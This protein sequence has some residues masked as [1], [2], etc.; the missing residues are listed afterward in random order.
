[1]LYQAY[2]LLEFFDLHACHASGDIYADAAV[3]SICSQQPSFSSV[4]FDTTHFENRNSLK[5]CLIMSKFLA[6]LNSEFLRGFTHIGCIYGLQITL[7][8]LRTLDMIVQFF[9]ETGRTITGN[10]AVTGFSETNSVL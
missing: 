6:I 5:A 1:M 3:E 10:S 7:N 9:S 4:Y 8:S 2:R